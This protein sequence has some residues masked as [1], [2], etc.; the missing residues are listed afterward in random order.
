VSNKKIGNGNPALLDIN[1]RHAIS[2]SMNLPELVSTIF[3]GYATPGTTIIPPIYPEFHYTPP[4]AT[5]YHFDPAKAE[6]ILNADGWKMGP[7][8]IRVKNGKQLN[9]RLFLRSDSATEVQAGQFIKG[10]LKDVGIDTEVKSYDDTQL[11]PII[12]KGEYDLF[13]WG[14]TP[15]VDPDPDVSGSSVGSGF[16]MRFTASSFGTGPLLST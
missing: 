14:W 5:A 3:L 11:T 12:G 10:W 16:S 7:K 15:F 6:Q 13:I 2:Y 1:V 9:L 8:G 4:A